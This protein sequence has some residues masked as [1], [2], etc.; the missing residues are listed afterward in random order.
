M[1]QLAQAT[2]VAVKQVLSPPSDGTTLAPHPWD[3]TLLPVA[4][5]R[6]RNPG[7]ALAAFS[8]NN[9]GTLL[10][11]AWRASPMT[12]MVDGT[13]YVVLGDDGGIQSFALVQ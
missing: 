9:R 11:Q 7:M 8:R 1:R 4:T 10:C 6:I 5:A 12:Y 3:G 2:A 13:Q